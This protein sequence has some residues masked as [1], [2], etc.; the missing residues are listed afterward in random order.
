MSALRL[1]Q[2]YRLV[3]ASFRSLRHLHTVDDQPR[4]FTAIAH[5]VAPGGCFAFNVFYPDY[6]SLEEVGTETQEMEWVDPD[7]GS[8]TVRRSYR[9]KAVDRLLQLIDGEF[10]FRSYRDGELVKEERAE[11]RMSYYTYPH[12][13]LLLRASGST[14]AEEHGSF[15]KEPISRCHEMIIVARKG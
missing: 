3:I 1:G 2:A 11:L 7:D 6:R 10:I 8:L 12:L 13:Q 15:E 4:A 5:H 14:V 9:R